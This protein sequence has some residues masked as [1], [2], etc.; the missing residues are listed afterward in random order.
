MLYFLHNSRDKYIQAEDFE[1][2]TR[3]ANGIFLTIFRQNTWLCI[4]I[5]FFRVVYETLQPFTIAS[6]LSSRSFRIVKDVCMT[7]TTTIIYGVEK[8]PFPDAC[9]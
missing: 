4:T 3:S 1:I 9:R 5:V 8:Q 2:F 7:K 6:D